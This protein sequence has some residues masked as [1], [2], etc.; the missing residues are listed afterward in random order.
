MCTL[1]LRLLQEYKLRNKKPYIVTYDDGDSEPLD[2]AQEKWQLLEQPKKS[3]SA[4]AAAAG[5]TDSKAD[6]EPAAAGSSKRNTKDAGSAG[7]GAAAAAPEGKELV[8]CHIKVWWTD[9]K[10]FYPGE[11]T[12]SA[13]QPRPARHP[14]RRL[15]GFASCNGWPQTRPHA[16]APFAD[17]L[18]VACSVVS[19]RVIAD[20]ALLDARGAASAA[21]PVST[22]WFALAAQHAHSTQHSGS[23]YCICFMRSCCVSC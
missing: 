14:Q 15:Y 23:G 2:L 4:A 6:S 5:Q 19:T 8:G 13:S 7:K 18:S 9:D 11:V 20:L 16:R 17:L 10:K 3:D 22:C 1:S 21:Q 12:V